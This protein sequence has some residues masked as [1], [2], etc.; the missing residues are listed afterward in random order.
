MA[1]EGRLQQKLADLEGV[2]NRL[3]QMPGPA[4]T[5]GGGTEW[6]K[7]IANPKEFNGTREKLKVLKNQLILKTSGNPARFP[8]TQHKLR[9]AYQFL[10]GKAHRTTRVH[11]RRTTGADGDETYKVL[12]S[13]FAAFLAPLYRH[14]GDPDERN[15]AASMLDKLRQG[16]REFGAYYTDFQEL[17]DILDNTDDTTRRHALKRGLNHEM[18]NALAIYPAPKDEEFDAYV[19][20][21]NELDYRLWAIRVQTPNHYQGHRHKHSTP[22][23]ATGGTCSNSTTSSGTDAGP[24]DLSAGAAKICI[25]AAECARCRAQGLC[26]YWRGVGHF[27]TNCSLAKARPAGKLRAITAAATIAA[28]TTTAGAT[29]SGS[30]RGVI[31]AIDSEDDSDLDQER[32][33]VA[34]V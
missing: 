6:A 27:A 10:T 17:M 18:L 32:K 8:N 28:A 33:G 29:G 15:T 31:T 12:F 21:L 1:A 5:T 3:V 4:T 19:E 11:L 34:Q 14:F 2:V 20:Q 16:N 22:N 30:G 23:E 7:K 26:M 25:T 24:M 13:S 9:Y